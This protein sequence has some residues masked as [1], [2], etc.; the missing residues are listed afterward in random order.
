VQISDE[1][2]E[3][4]SKFSISYKVPNSC[5]SWSKKYNEAYDNWTKLPDEEVNNEWKKKILH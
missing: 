4:N 2:I 1:N 5:N 3:T